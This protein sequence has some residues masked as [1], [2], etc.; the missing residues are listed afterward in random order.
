MLN[1]LSRS[2]LKVYPTVQFYRPSFTPLAWHRRS[3][4][5]EGRNTNVQ[6]IVRSFT[7]RVSPLPPLSLFNMVMETATS[8]LQIWPK[9]YEYRRTTFEFFAPAVH[10]AA[11]VYVTLSPPPTTNQS[12][13]CKS[14][15]KPRKYPSERPNPYRAQMAARTGLG[16]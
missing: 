4:R 8:P 6:P 7:F 10:G 15:L 5:D 3:L 13:G 1:R 9:L 14:T 2:L 11:P 16:A 12:Y